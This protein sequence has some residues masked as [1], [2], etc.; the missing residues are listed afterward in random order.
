MTEGEI[1]TER[2]SPIERASEVT[3]TAEDV[4]AYMARLE[5][6]R[7]MA[8]SAQAAADRVGPGFKTAMVAA[9]ELFA[10]EEARLTKYIEREDA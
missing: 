4:N 10:D 2:V 1:V 9:T 5:D 7:N 8:R 6:L 3:P